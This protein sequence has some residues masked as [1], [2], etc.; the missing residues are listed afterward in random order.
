[1]M[2]YIKS[3]MY[4][5]SHDK[6]VTACIALLSAL[7]VL[8]NAIL[9]WFGKRDGASFRYNT[10]SFSYSNLVAN[11]MVFCIM[12]ALIGILLYEGNRKNGNLKNTI[13]FGIPRIKIFAG[14]CI[15]AVITAVIS[16]LIV[17]SA[18]II[19][20]IVCLEHTGPVNLNDLLTEIPAVFLLAFASLISGIVCMEA[21]GKAVVGTIVWYSIWFLIPKIFFYLGLRIDLFHR[22]AMWMPENFFGTSAMHVNM[23]Q[24]ITI[25]G[26][27]EGMVRC[28]IAGSIGIIVFSIW[29]IVSMQKREL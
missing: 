27:P 16:L 10:T 21:F 7:A 22:I 28:I 26:T 25:W 12:G 18:Y 13:A 5:I 2:N 3:E 14:E 19:S 15:S 20:A 11:P 23:S 1:M 17:L 8:F 9:G 6:G 29:G 24:S 4:R